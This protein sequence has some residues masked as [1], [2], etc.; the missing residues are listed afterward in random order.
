[1]MLVGLGEFYYDLP[2]VIDHRYISKKIPGFLV[3]IY[4]E[5][6]SL[7]KSPGTCKNSEASSSKRV[8]S[9]QDMKHDLHFMAW[10]SL[11]RLWD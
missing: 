2:E 8:A 6:F 5:A 10:P 3:P 11:Y 7:Y 9:Q 1:M 4:I